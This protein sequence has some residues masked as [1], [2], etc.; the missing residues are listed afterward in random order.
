[1][2]LVKSEVTYHG[3]TV[4]QVTCYRHIP[5]EGR[6]AHQASQKFRFIVC[7]AFLLLDLEILLLDGRNDGHLH[8]HSE[9][10]KSYLG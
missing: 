8:F 5:D 7:D 10:M 1:M 6:A 2:S 3:F 4:M 9:G